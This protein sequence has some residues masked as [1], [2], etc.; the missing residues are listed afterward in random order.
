[1]TVLADPVRRQ[2]VELLSEGER[3]AGEIVAHFEISQPSVSRH[4]KVLREAGLVNVQVDANRRIYSLNPK[5]LEQV[6]DWAARHLAMW[7]RHFDR[8]GAHLDQM[9]AADLDERNKL[10]GVQHANGDDDDAR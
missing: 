1:M 4:L 8:L 10:R 6:E 9:E 5:P 3:S 7:H 2:V